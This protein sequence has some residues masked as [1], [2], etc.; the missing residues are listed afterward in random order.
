MAYGGKVMKINLEAGMPTVD[1][2]LRNLVNRLSTCKGQGCKAAI[3]VHG[4][5][6][7]GVGGGIRLA[8]RKKL[9]EPSLVGMIRSVCPGEEWLNRKDEMIRQC[10]FLRDYDREIHGN[11][12]VTV[13]TFK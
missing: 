11:A 10:T 6:S 9:K 2:A 8:V 7:S 5:G 1:V 3:L 4:Y 12:G 13:V